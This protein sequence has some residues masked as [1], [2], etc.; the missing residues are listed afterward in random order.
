[1]V[2][3]GYTGWG[4]GGEAMKKISESMEGKFVYLIPPMDTHWILTFADDWDHLREGVGMLRRVMWL[5]L[6]DSIHAENSQH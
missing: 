5:D 2:S 3:G 1:M 4:E 6:W